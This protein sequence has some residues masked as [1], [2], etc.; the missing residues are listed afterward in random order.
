MAKY[1]VNIEL[2]ADGYGAQVLGVGLCDRARA[3]FAL[4][5][6]GHPM[7]TWN[8][9][10]SPA[11]SHRRAPCL[12]PQRTRRAVSREVVEQSSRTVRAVGLCVDP[13]PAPRRS[14][15]PTR[16]ARNRRPSARHARQPFASRPPILNA[17][18]PKTALQAVRPSARACHAPAVHAP[19]RRSM[20]AA[21]PF[22]CHAMARESVGLSATMRI[23]YPQA[24]A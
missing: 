2:R 21:S 7:R 24:R 16:R 8:G 13:R 1:M 20:R 6:L 11:I 14:P 23:L 17:N 12:C 10:A 5:C 19:L 22:R 15:Q 9:H 3:L 18:A 4:G